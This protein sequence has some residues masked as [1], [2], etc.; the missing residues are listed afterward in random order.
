MLRILLGIVFATAAVTG[1][2]MGT[3]AAFG[4]TEASLAN[5]ISAASID[6]EV[7]LKI[8][9]A[10][11]AAVFG[12]SDL[13][14]TGNTMLLTASGVFP[15]EAAYAGIG[16]RLKGDPL[17]DPPAQVSLRMSRHDD[18]D[19][20]CTEPEIVEEPAC[21]GGADP[22]ELDNISELLIFYDYGIDNLPGPAGDPAENNLGQDGAEVTIFPWQSVDPNIPASPG[23]IV[24]P[25]DA[26][27]NTPAVIDPFVQGTTYYITVIWNFPNAAGFSDNV[28]QTDSFQM[29]MTFEA[30]QL[31]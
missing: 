30:L 27:P 12:P 14:P 6:L 15:G 23:E 20:T 25:L 8:S 31:P 28:A 1:V 16:L 26:N 3:L 24:F 7:D 9:D 11:T 21:A 19:V 13:D 29:D 10:N 17:V 5:E 18:I 4:D 22:G 2:T